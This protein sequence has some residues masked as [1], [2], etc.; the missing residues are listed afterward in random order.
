M[1]ER[2]QL[3]RAKGWQMP[4]N[5]VAVARPSKWGN[6]FK[7]TE[8]RGPREAVMAY[9]IWLGVDGC[10]AG[11]P[12]RKAAILEALSDLRGKNLACWCK[13]GT[14]CHA[15]VLLELANRPTAGGPNTEGWNG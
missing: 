6:P 4:A 9:R 12:A 7:I 8:E 3:S 15:D 11:V 1:P 2:I 14:P 5:T 10:D 13:L